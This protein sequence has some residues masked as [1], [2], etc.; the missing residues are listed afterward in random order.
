[1]KMKTGSVYWTMV[2]LN[3]YDV[4]M[5]QRSSSLVMSGTENN[6]TLNLFVQLLYHDG[7][8]ELGMLAL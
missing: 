3:G 2:I 4:M 7:I 6:I 1:M 8:R 5:F